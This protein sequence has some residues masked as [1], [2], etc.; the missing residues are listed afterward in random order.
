[1]KHNLINNSSETLYL[2][3]K[4]TLVGVTV[5]VVVVHT[6]R[7]LQGFLFYP[8]G[9]AVV[10]LVMAFPIAE[11]SALGTL[12]LF[13]VKDWERVSIFGHAQKFNSRINN[14]FIFF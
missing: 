9:V 11:H 13:V 10:G 14:V 6:L 8:F 1:M 5:I 4:I 2:F 7:F 3:Q 12:L